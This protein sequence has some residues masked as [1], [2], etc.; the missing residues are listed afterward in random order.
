MRRYL[1]PLLILFGLM[2]FGGVAVQSWSAEA[3]AGLTTSRAMV[4]VAAGLGAV[5]LIGLSF[6]GRTT[7]EA[8]AAGP[9]VPLTNQSSRVIFYVSLSAGTTAFLLLRAAAAG[10][11]IG[12][13]PALDKPVFTI[14]ANFPAP[15]GGTEVTEMDL[16]LAVGPMVIGGMLVVGIGLAQTFALL[17]KQ[18]RKV[19]AAAPDKPA[20]R[21]GPAAKAESGLGVPLTNHRSLVTFYVILAAGLAIFLG[22]RARALGTPVGYIPLPDAA[23]VDRLPGDPIEGVPEFLPAPG[24]PL[25]E[26]QLLLLALPAVVVSVAV[27]GVGLAWLVNVYSR[28]EQTVA[29]AGPAWP[30]PGSQPPVILRVNWSDPALLM[31][32]LVVLGLMITLVT[33]ILIGSLVAGQSAQ[34][35]EATHV[36]AAWTPTPVPVVGPSAEETFGQLP[37]GD[38]ARGETTFTVAGCAACHSLEPGVTIVGPSQAGLAARAAT[39]EPGASP[40]FYIYESIVQPNAVVV[41]GFQPGLMPATFGQTLTPQDLADLLAYLMTLQ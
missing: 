10:T 24:Q 18:N 35:A 28:Q 11:P 31:L 15:L 17:D 22:L 9:Q 32:L 21:A 5:V 6:A 37:V 27:V 25:T 29:A 34:V 7:T 41:E 16:M 14:P 2:A 33:P 3:E 8:Q 20:G 26:A 12:Y 30:A 38:A 40:E 19:E 36:A 1:L 4:L 23:V 13:V 39:R